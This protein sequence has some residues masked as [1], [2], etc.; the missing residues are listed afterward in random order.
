MFEIVEIIGAIAT[1]IAIYAVWLNT[2]ANKSSFLLFMVSNALIGGLH[3]YDGRM[4]LMAG[5]AVFFG[6]AFVGYNR[7]SRQE[8]LKEGK[9]L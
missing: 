2:K 5:D 3:L 1:F 4:S 9:N 8:K 6:L 7:W